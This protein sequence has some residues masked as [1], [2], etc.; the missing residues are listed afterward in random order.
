MFRGKAKKVKLSW[1]QR[2]ASAKNRNVAVVKNGGI[3]NTTTII[4]NSKNIAVVE[5]QDGYVEDEESNEEE[6]A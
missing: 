4:F 3:G 5:G 1:E 2:I 6:D